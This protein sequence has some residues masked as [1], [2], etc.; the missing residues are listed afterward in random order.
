LA[1]V[2][3]LPALSFAA[4]IFAMLFWKSRWLTLCAAVP[5]AAVPVSASL[6]TNYLAT[7][8]FRPFY[9]YYG[10]EKYRYFLDGVP[11]Y[12]MNPGG[13]DAN[14]ESPWSY[15][16]HCTLGH[17]GIFSLSPIF[18]IALVAWIIPP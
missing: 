8:G 18:L 12:W 9:A 7:G 14:T 16:L 5:A 2:N 6:T 17:H 4:A 11:S 15:L 10:T 3:E 1:A 13:L